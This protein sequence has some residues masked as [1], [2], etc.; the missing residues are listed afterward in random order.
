MQ[1]AA[2]VRKWAE[3]CESERK[4]HPRAA[5]PTITVGLFVA[6]RETHALLE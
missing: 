1:Y 3:V 2:R 5:I 6:L 4:V